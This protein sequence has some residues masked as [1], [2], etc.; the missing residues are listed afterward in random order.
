MGLP[1]LQK[2]QFF[3]L[4]LG[5]VDVGTDSLHGLEGFQQRRVVTVLPGRP[6]QQLLFPHLGGGGREKE[7]R[8]FDL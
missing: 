6:L 7:K 1:L 3:H 8:V 2:L 4:S 5:L